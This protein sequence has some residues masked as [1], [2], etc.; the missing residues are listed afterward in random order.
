MSAS[1]LITLRALL[2]E[3]TGLVAKM[4]A[5]EERKE[6]GGDDVWID[7]AIASE[8]FGVPHDSIRYLCREKGYGRKVGG[9]WEANATGLHDY[10]GKR[11]KREKTTRVSRAISRL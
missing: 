9:R 7:T 3:I 6:S 1:D 2:G 11:E 4:E 8:R 10:F 5:E